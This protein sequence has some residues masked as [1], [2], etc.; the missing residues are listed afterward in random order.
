PRILISREEGI[1]NVNKYGEE[2]AY[3]TPIDNPYVI[4]LLN[5][6]GFDTVESLLEDNRIFTRKF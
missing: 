3:Q 1:E 5:R 6:L 4:E 2:A